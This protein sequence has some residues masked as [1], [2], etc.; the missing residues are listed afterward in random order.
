MGAAA[1]RNIFTIEDFSSQGP[2]TDGRVKPDIVG[3][4]N[5]Q[6]AAYGGAFEGTSQASPHVA[7]LAALVKQRFPD[8]SPQQIATYLKTHAEARGSVPNNTWGYGFAKLVASDAATPTPEPTVTPLP[9]P[10]PTATPEPTPEP[11]PT[12]TPEPT[13]EPTATPEP[14]P[15]ADPCVENL[16]ADT[17]IQGSWSDDCPSESRSGSYASYYTFSHSQNPPT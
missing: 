2:T 14:T 9:T 5:V 11:T 13:P 8:Y 15:P 16:D 3:A 10:E 1:V 6:S 17:T 12:P 7:G 4:D